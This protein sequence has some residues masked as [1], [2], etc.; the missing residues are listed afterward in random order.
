[1]GKRLGEHLLCRRTVLGI[2]FIR[3]EVI[4]DQETFSA[5][6]VFV[7]VPWTSF[8]I[9]KGMPEQIRDSIRGLKYS[10]IETR[11]FEEN[12]ADTNWH[13]MPK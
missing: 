6:I 13:P 4:T 10:S 3:K 9:L 8:V 11:Y 2:D 5:D 1:M 7:T 12:L